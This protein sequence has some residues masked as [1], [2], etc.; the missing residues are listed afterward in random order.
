LP[1]PEQVAELGQGRG[2]ALAVALEQALVDLGAE[3]AG[4]G[5][6]PLAVALEQ[7]PVHARLVEVALQE[8]AETSR[9]RLA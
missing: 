2:R 7:L 4:G 1:G 5:D 6:Q 3:A 8:A 9:S